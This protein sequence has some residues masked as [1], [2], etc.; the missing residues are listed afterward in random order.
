M[1][2]H[3]CACMPCVQVFE[4]VGLAD[5]PLLLPGILPPEYWHLIILGFR[6]S[7]VAAMSIIRQKQE[8]S[9]WLLAPK[10]AYFVGTGSCLGTAHHRLVTSTSLTATNHVCCPHPCSLAVARGIPCS[11]TSLLSSLKVPES[12]Q[13]ALFFRHAPHAKLCFAYTPKQCAAVGPC[14]I[15]R[16]T[17]SFDLL[18]SIRFGVL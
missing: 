15:P 7:L 6:T 3:L 13:L 14:R 5:A 9:V 18:V 1:D 11:S 12:P 8:T 10:E 16:N 4:R 17:F 2:R